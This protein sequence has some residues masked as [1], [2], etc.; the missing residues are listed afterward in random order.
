M[1]SSVV[2]SVSPWSSVSKNIGEVSSMREAMVNA[3]VDYTISKEPLCRSDGSIIPNHF[4]VMRND[5]KAIFDVVKNSWKPLQN[6]CCFNFFDVMLEEESIK[7]D[8]VGSIRGGERMFIVAKINE[9]P[10][11]ITGEDTIDKYIILINNHNK[12][13]SIRVG[14]TPIRMWCTN[15][16]PSIMRNNQSQILK[17]RHARSPRESLE[18]LKEILNVANAQFSATQEQLRFLASKYINYNDLK[19]YVKTVMQFE[20][21]D[22]D[23][24][25]RSINVMEKIIHLHKHGRGNSLVGVRGTWY[26]SFNAIN[27]HLNYFSGRSVDTRLESLWLGKNATLNDK[28]MA[29]ALEMAG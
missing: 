27:E 9:P 13:S 15:M 17:I 19:K 16:L 29:I 2:K 8:S 10:M 3:G 24:S 25:T 14:F 28:A 5:T 18:G 21:K 6:L 7:I 22:E 26:A 20:E 11:S 4:G 12:K 23:M 1:V